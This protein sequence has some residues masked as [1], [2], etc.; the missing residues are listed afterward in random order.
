MTPDVPPVQ[1]STP[2]GVL[3][4][5][6]PEQLIQVQSRRHFR[7]GG[8][9]GRH[10][11]AW[12]RWTAQ[13]TRLPVRDLSEEGV[14][15]ELAGPDLPGP[16]PLGAA[17]LLLDDEVIDVP[18]LETVHCMAARNGRPATV[19]ARL[20]GMRDEQVRALRRWMAVVQTE[21]LGAAPGQA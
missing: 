14:C 20:L 12:L 13:G 5:D 4:A 21:A 2:S 19:G 9:G 11:R 6:W 1:Q 10:R 8:L 15:L 7:L 18:S 16:L 3:H 17:A